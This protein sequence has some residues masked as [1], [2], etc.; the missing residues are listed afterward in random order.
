MP[1]DR[2]SPAG[3]DSPG[4][5]EGPADGGS[6]ADGDGRAGHD[7]PGRAEALSSVQQRLKRYADTTDPEL[8]LEPATG[9]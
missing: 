2:D 8:I 7:G 5:C 4:D 6:P 3:G 1:T 9:M